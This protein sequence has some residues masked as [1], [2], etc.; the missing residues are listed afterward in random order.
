LPREKTRQKQN[1]GPSDRER[2][3]IDV[4]R[5]VVGLYS[6]WESGREEI[7]SM[8]EQRVEASEDEVRMALILLLCP[9]ITRLG[10]YTDWSRR[11]K[12]ELLTEMLE[13]GATIRQT[14]AKIA[15]VLGSIR[16]RIPE[17]VRAVNLR[18]TS[19]GDWNASFVTNVLNLPALEEL[20]IDGVTDM[21]QPF[22]QS[23]GIAFPRI[24]TLRLLFCDG[25]PWAITEL[26]RKCLSLT[27]LEI[28]WANNWCGRSDAEVTYLY[29]HAEGRSTSVQHLGAVLLEIA[30]NL[31]VLTLANSAI[32]EDGQ[33]CLGSCLRGL[34]FLHTLNVGVDFVW[35]VPGLRKRLAEVVPR[36]VVALRLLAR[37]EYDH[38]GSVRGATHETQLGYMAQ[39][40]AD[41]RDLLQHELYERLAE[42]TVDYHAYHRWGSPE[43]LD[44]WLRRIEYRR[45]DVFN[46]NVARCGWSMTEDYKNGTQTLRRQLIPRS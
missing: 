15:G 40:D 6:D 29:H 46:E 9:N 22:L 28:T 36:S 35:P 39:T 44:R 21:Y 43:S 12:V 26:L 24:S 14:D 23:A 20:S 27:T 2:I 5:E 30:P 8:M 7:L 45:G 25:L 16:P 10:V 19:V 31:Q 33:F 17:K 32:P 3:E 11:F 37:E 18:T 34:R 4:R 13:T 41:V 38:W 1:L 42:V